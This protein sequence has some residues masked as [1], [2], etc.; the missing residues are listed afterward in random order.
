M[1][2]WTLNWDEIRSDLLIG[3]F[4][5]TADDLATIK[6]ETKATAIL[7]V[8]T[9]Q[10]LDHFGLKYEDQLTNGESIGLKMVR[11]PM[12]DFNPPD[13]RLNLPNAVRA[14]NRLLV[15]G[16][17]VYVH[18]T[19]GMGRSAL[20]IL[21]YL[22]FIENFTPDDA[23]S[24][25]KR[26]RNCVVP[27]LEAYQGCHHDLIKENQKEIEQ[28]ARCLSTK[29]QYGSKQPSDSDWSQAEQAVIRSVLSVG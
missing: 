16:H 10:C 26:R 24:L 25:L 7:S 15:D 4:P 11:A 21:G 2:V 12:L 1:W 14:L 13:Q 9:D 18:C 8:Q 27:N 6:V 28:F 17:R 20:T 29:R 22:T 23:L 3:S 5:M 19:A